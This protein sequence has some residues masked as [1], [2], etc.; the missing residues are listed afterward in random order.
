LWKRL[1]VAFI[2]VLAVIGIGAFL[3]QQSYAPILKP[4]DPG[5]TLPQPPSGDDQKVLLRLAGSNTIGGELAPALVKEYLVSRGA[6]NVKAHS[7]AKDETL[8]RQS[9]NQT[10]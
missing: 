5:P 3:Y 10:G 2:C 4:T 1:I 9:R 6:A 7:T 8:S